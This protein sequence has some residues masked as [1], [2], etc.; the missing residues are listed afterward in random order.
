MVLFGID[1]WQLIVTL[2]VW[3]F[4]GIPVKNAFL[5][6]WRQLPFAKLKA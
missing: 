6:A 3:S 2:A 4:F 1:L 5:W